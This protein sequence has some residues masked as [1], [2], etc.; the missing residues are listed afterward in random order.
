MEVYIREYDVCE[1][2]KADN[3]QP[4]G[5]LQPIDMQAVPWRDIAIDL[6]SGLPC[7]D[8]CSLILVVTD[9]FLKMVHLI[10]LDN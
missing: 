8:E 3:R 5:E 10:P 6:V 7:L 2:T 9:W 4:V 1:Q